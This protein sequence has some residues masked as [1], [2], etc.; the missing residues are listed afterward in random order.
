MGRYQASVSEVSSSGVAK[1]NQLCFR[2][3]IVLLLQCLE[4]ANTLRQKW[5]QRYK[6]EEEALISSW[7]PIKFSKD[8][9]DL[10]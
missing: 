10:T 5:S 4:A 9:Q 1:V 6:D 3:T 8:L 2:N 7:E